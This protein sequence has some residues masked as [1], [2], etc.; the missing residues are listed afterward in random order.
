MYLGVS[1]EE[2]PAILQD[3]R[4]GSKEKPVVCGPML[5][6]MRKH[7]ETPYGWTVVNT[8]P[9]DMLPARILQRILLVEFLG[10]GKMKKQTPAPGHCFIEYWSSITFATIC[11]SKVMRSYIEA[12][13]IYAENEHLKSSVSMCVCPKNETPT[14]RMTWL[15]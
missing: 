3:D 13:T 15:V 6:N 9:A 8:I 11:G 7:R 1:P 12:T 4:V 10:R 14:S 2:T 5:K